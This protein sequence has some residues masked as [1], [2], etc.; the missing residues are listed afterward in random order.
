MQSI[1]AFLLLF[2]STSTL[3]Q[4][5]WPDAAPEEWGLAIIDVETTGLEP[6]HH[7]MIDIGMIYTTLDGDELGRLF[8]R[9]HPRH[10]ERAGEVARSING[11]SEERWAALDALEAEAAAMRILEF[12]RE[13]AHARRFIL[14]AY[15]APFDRAFVDAFLKRHQSSVRD[16]YTHFV[17]D[18][19]SMA[20]GL[21]ATA[22]ANGRTAAYFGIEPETED[23]LQ[24][25]GLSGAA[26]NLELYRAL[27]RRSA[28]TT[29]MD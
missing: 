12:H 28:E 5:P 18:L 11:Y 8:L 23:P 2:V 17:L 4:A 29:K 1:F 22:L 13:H 24:H 21:G 27:R 7:E 6:G 9:I 25:T 20:F 10:P 26:W 16:L 15:N 14:T 19:P 3:A